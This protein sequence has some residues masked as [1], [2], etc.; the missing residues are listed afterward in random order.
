MKELMIY[1]ERCVRPVRAEGSKKLAMRKELLSHLESI[2]EQERTRGKSDQ[3][4]VQAAIA[5]MGDSQELTKELSTSLSLLDRWTGWIDSLTCRKIHESPR[6][7]ALRV[8]RLTLKASLL[9]LVP[10]AAVIVMWAGKLES[11]ELIVIRVC[12]GIV[13]IET[14]VCLIASWFFANVRDHLE[15]NGWGKHL[16]PLAAK[17]AIS[18]LI[19]TP[20]LGWLFFYGVSFDMDGA[21]AYLPTWLLLGSLAGPGIFWAAWVDAKLTRG[22]HEWQEL[23]IE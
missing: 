1:V 10:F 15:L 4:A 6:D 3:A 5:R 9:F 21:T 12:V 18:F 16:L 19:L 20:I 14:I 2:Y 23:E 11:K 17:T 7:F 8:S 22:L 13:L